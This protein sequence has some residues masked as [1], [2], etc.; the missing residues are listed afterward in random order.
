[1]E[2]VFVHRRLDRRHLGDL[3][4]DRFGVVALQLLVA[5]AALGR[6]AVDDLADLLGGYE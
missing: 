1:M 6:L 3:V 2:P 5:P 4:S